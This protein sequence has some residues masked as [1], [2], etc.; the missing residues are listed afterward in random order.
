MKEKL[1][2]TNNKQV[3][4]DW[5]KLDDYLKK[6]KGNWIELQKKLDCIY[7]DDE[8]ID[9]YYGCFQGTI[10]NKKGIFELSYFVDVINEDEYDDWDNDVDIR[11]LEKGKL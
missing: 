1:Y 6:F 5:H 9:V 11:L 3:L 10:H 2:M 7:S 8:V 4:K